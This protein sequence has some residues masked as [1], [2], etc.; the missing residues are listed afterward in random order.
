[1][2]SSSRGAIPHD[3][4]AA[5]LDPSSGERSR[6]GGLCTQWRFLGTGLLGLQPGGGEGAQGAFACVGQE[7]PRSLSLDRLVDAL[8]DAGLPVE[9]LRA[10]QLKA[11]S[12][13]TTAT[14]YPDGDGGPA[15]LFDARDCEQ[16]QWMARDVLIWVTRALNEGQGQGDDGPSSE[17]GS[18]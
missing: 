11:L 4:S 15:D 8:A 7:P 18:S 13:M 5:G 2:P 9:T 17:Q 14:R 16:A 10:L 1:M 6:H 12:R 3:T